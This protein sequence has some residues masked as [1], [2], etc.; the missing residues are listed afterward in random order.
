VKGRR[1][2]S[3][4][5]FAFC[6]P[7]Y[8]V[9][10]SLFSSLF[11]KGT[12][13]SEATSVSIVALRYKATRTKRKPINNSTHPSQQTPPRRSLLLL[14]LLVPTISSPIL[15]PLLPPLLLFLPPLLLLLH[16]LLLN[17]RLRLQQRSR[18]SSRLRSPSDIQPLV[19]IRLLLLLLFFSLPPRR[20]RRRGPKR[21]DQIRSLFNDP[22]RW[23]ER[24]S[25]RRRRNDGRTVVVWV[26]G[27]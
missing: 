6:L 14:L 20:R 4:A 22:R 27:R 18:W 13:R 17:L 12:Q 23:L 21:R 19:R 26:K 25:S 5:F 10:R 24:E 16:K 1:S 2:G 8:L 9:L 3:D 15:I 7:S 11:S